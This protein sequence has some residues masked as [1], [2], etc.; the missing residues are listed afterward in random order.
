MA[1]PE[2]Q[3]ETWSHQGSI[4]QSKTTYATIKNALLATDAPYAAKKP[5][6]FLQGSYG[7]DTNI[8]SESDVDVVIRLDSC[9]Q[10]DL[11]EL[12]QAQKD[13]FKAAHS[14]AT[15]THVDFKRDVLSQLG[16]QFGTDVKPGTKAVKI[17]ANNN[18]RN[19]DVLIAI[20]FRRYHRFIALDDQDYDL[21]ICFYNSAGTRIANYP[22]QHSENC[23]AKHQATNSWFKP[24]VR[25]VKNMRG[26][27]AADG[28][29]TGDIAPSYYIEGLLYNVPHD[30]FGGSYEDSFV[31]CINWILGA[32]RSQFVCANRQY[33]LLRDDPD[34]TWST[35]KCDQFLDAVVDLWK[36]W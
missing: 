36:R 3:L 5:A 28:V 1:I 29:L 12:P 34:V 22:K 15:Y 10:H 21:G 20:Q 6:V 35:T 30:K 16:K 19:A 18:R 27:L 17:M 2:S 13:A 7:N 25:I 11:K 31:N 32:D 4:D 14:D 26:K 33:Y 9:F 23:T 8:Y 24:L